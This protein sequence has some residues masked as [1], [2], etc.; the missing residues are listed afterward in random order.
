M[1]ITLNSSKKELY[2]PL[3]RKVSSMRLSGMNGCYTGALFLL[4]SLDAI[5]FFPF[6]LRVFGL[7]VSKQTYRQHPGFIDWEIS[8]DGV[9][10]KR[11]SA[12]FYFSI[13][14][15]TNDSKF[16]QR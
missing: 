14:K 4:Y 12:K 15:G 7:I 10:H 13:K 2:N 16:F 11:S 1:I 9:G 5:S 3:G 8:R 6:S